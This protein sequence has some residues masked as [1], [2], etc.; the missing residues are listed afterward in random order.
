[1]EMS[2]C[3]VGIP[4]LPSTKILEIIIIIYIYISNN[5]SW[6]SEK[7]KIYIERFS[8]IQRQLDYHSNFTLALYSHNSYISRSRQNGFL[9]TG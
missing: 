3:Y 5:I 2:T 1:M 7:F 9:S 4:I 8:P 6:Y